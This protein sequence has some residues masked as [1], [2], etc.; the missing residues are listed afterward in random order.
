MIDLVNYNKDVMT[1]N[2]RP[3]VFLSDYIVE[4]FLSCCYSRGFI[5]VYHVSSYKH[6]GTR[7]KLEKGGVNL[8]PLEKFKANQQ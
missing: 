5:F 8:N 1:G 4:M 2:K 6:A 3:L 7:C